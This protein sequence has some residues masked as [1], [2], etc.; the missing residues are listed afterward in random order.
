MPEPSLRPTLAEPH[1]ER[2]SYQAAVNG[3][4]PALCDDP[5]CGPCQASAAAWEA[6]RRDA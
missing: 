4:Y 6:E 1:P 5:G 3:D 2:Y